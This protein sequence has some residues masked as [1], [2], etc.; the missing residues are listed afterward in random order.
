M[1]VRH[2]GKYTKLNRR[3]PRGLGV[4]D[5]SGLM[6]RHADMIRQLEYRGTSKV[7]TGYW[8]NP[9]FADTPNP[10][11]LIPLIRLD[12]IPLDHARPDPIV[13]DVSV[14]TLT[15]DIPSQATYPN[16]TLTNTQFDNTIFNFTGVLTQDIIIYVPATFNEF[17]ANNLTTG[18]FTLS[19]Q[20]MNQYSTDPLIIP[21]A[22]EI[23]QTGPLVVND[24]LKLSIIPNA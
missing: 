23:T 22:N 1:G 4:C 10:Q 3:N 15:F 5:Y 20:L 7:W 2:H 14:P 24:A 19:M 21:P 18:G 12:P 11:N 8:V 17:Y 16:I 13:Y 6:V 9:K